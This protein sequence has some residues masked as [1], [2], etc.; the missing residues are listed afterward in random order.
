[1]S[2]KTRSSTEL[3][4]MIEDILDNKLANLASKDDLVEIKNFSRI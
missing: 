4:K 3:A 2:Q 1:M